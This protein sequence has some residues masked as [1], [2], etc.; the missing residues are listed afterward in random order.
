[1]NSQIN[2][3]VNKI[4]VS[5]AI[6]AIASY[7]GVSFW[8]FTALIVLM[9]FDYITG[10]WAA[11]VQKLKNPEDDSLGWNS[12]KGKLGALMKVGYI[13]VIGNCFMFDY[14][15][16]IVMTEFNQSVPFNFSLGVVMLVYFV[17]TELISNLENINKVDTKYV[18]NF[19]IDFVSSVKTSF[20]KYIANRLLS[21]VTKEDTEE[22]KEK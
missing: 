11:T 9:V 3:I 21:F 14:V 4:L 20:G 17:G 1:M 6:G 13:F 18:P 7:F 15:I 19:L 2:T 8:L 10:I 22:T 16:K 5:T 12:S